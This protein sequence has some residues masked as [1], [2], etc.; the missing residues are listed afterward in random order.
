MKSTLSRILASTLQG[1]VFYCP[2][3]GKTMMYFKVQWF[4]FERGGLLDF[5]KGL[6]RLLLDKP[7]TKRLIDEISAN[8][9]GIGKSPD[10][11]PSL[12]DLTE[13]LDLVDTALLVLEAQEIV[14]KA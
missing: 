13:M 10:C 4:E 8:A 12:E 3:R 5:R 1:K 7:F 14:G 11:L 9:A 6:A 2:C